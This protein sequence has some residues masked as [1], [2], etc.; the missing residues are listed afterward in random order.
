MERKRKTKEKAASKPAIR[1]QKES[2][3]RLKANYSTIMFHYQL[4]I[5]LFHVWVVSNAAL[6][7]ALFLTF[8]L[9]GELRKEIDSK[10]VVDF[11]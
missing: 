3:K 9:L 5:G 4:L 7:L 11:A 8:H 10:K 2:D 1:A 6:S